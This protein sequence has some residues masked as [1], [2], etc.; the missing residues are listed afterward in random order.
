MVGKFLEVE[1]SGTE[2]P[3]LQ[4]VWRKVWYKSLG[5]SVPWDG[6]IVIVAALVVVLTALGTQSTLEIWLF[7]SLY[8]GPQKKFVWFFSFFFNCIGCSG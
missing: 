6:I 7:L 3:M 1:P 8:M 2:I 5:P 4:R